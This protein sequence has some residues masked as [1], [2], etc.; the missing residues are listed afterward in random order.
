MF[1][2]KYFNFATEFTYL[3][4]LL[5]GNNSMS[6]EIK[7]RIGKENKSHFKKKS[8]KPVVIH[9]YKNDE[10]VVKYLERKLLWNI[11]GPVQKPVETWQKAQKIKWLEHIFRIDEKR[12][13]WK[14]SL[15]G[16]PPKSHPEE[17]RQKNG[18]HVWKKTWEWRKNGVES[19]ELEVQ[20]SWKSQNPQYTKAA[21][22]NKVIP[23]NQSVCF[24]D[25][26]ALIRE[27]KWWSSN[28]YHD[29]KLPVSI[30]LSLDSLSQ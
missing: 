22:W 25:S 10:E 7:T 20:N 2:I 23:W 27:Q 9:N 30:T 1:K 26:Q 24:T 13:I 15:N 12:K 6:R 16:N 11:F 4:P 28:R 14:I 5:N 29:V 3:S 21:S 17:F 18:W 8:I 19:L